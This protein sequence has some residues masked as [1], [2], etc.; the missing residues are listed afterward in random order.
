MRGTN[1]DIKELEEKKL[2]E[3]YKYAKEYQIPYYGTMKK[4]ELIFS[5]LKAQA[6]KDGL[7]FAAGVLEIMQDGYGFLRPVGYLPSQ[8]DI[9]VAASQ[10]RRFDLRT[11]DFV[12]GKVRPL[13]KMN[14]T[15]VYFTWKP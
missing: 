4:R 1:L 11:G 15:L 3:L 7:I 6:E 9:Y 13:R 5:I 12:S 10:I 2:T 14:A 8:E